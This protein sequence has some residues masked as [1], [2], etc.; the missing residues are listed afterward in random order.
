MG[1]NSAAVFFPQSD[2]VGADRDKPA[3][4]N[5]ELTMELN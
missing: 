3:I 1:A 4:G 2:I 5:L